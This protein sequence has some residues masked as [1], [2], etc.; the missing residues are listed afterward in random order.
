MKHKRSI[1][2]GI[3]I[4]FFTLIFICGLL[5][6]LIAYFT[7]SSYI[8]KGISE[9]YLNTLRLYRNGI[10]EKLSSVDRIMDFLFASSTLKTLALS[11]SGA[12]ERVKME[13][14]LDES[15]RMMIFS[16]D[17][18]ECDEISVY[19]PSGLC[20]SF[21]DSYRKYDFSPFFESD[22]GTDTV[23]YIVEGSTGTQVIAMRSFLNNSY[24][25]FIGKIFLHFPSS[26][27]FEELDSY[28]LAFTS[29]GRLLFGHDEDDNLES[30]INN[31]NDSYLS[32]GLDSIDVI[33][34]GTIPSMYDT[35]EF[36]VLV[37]T[38]LAVIILSVFFSFLEWRLLKKNVL[39]FISA[40][41]SG[42]KRMEEDKKLTLL[43]KKPNA[44]GE[45]RDLVESYN[46]VSITL[47]RLVEDKINAAIEKKED[48]YKILMN[49]INP[50][51]INNAI[52][53]IRWMATINEN[54]NIAQYAE[55]LSLFIRNIQKGNEQIEYRLRDE[56]ECVR[57]YIF[58]QQIALKNR[59]ISEINV[60]D[61]K[62][63]D[64]KC[65]HFFLQPIVEN[66]ILH[67]FAEK[68]GICT[69]IISVRRGEVA[70]H[71]AI[72][73]SVFDDGVG[74]YE[75]PDRKK[76]VTGIGLG[77]V[78]RRFVSEYGPSYTP[79]IFSIKGEFTEIVLHIPLKEE[80]WQTS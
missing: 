45:V 31:E 50:H 39:Y 71:P 47:D 66:S 32:I 51:F 35:R 20:Y 37:V 62:L 46:N 69:L 52:N 40:V 55:K 44:E 56:L 21:S 1:E 2:N 49:Q 38:V 16:M 65:L 36:Y 23:F 80:L 72:E 77:S 63:L 42:L 7:I 75:E 17:F 59:F 6:L 43:E 19:G 48:E 26:Y 33:L 11:E 68:E 64:V 29:E 34:A 79:E 67:G 57:N 24:T 53:T 73:I 18:E 61:E 10:E 60:E 74:F 25:E 27:L 30:I 5:I 4:H 13:E 76:K 14:S 54:E 3:F 22:D 15:L 58:I 70:G 12:Y 9:T 78:T 41:S 8:K 28:V